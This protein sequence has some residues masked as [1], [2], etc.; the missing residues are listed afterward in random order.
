MIKSKKSPKEILCGE[1]LS[2]ARAEGEEICRLASVEADNILKR[3][4]ED[5]QK[6]RRVLLETAGAEAALRRELMVAAVPVEAARLRSARIEALLQTIRAEAGRRLLAPPAEGPWRKEILVELA[7]EAVSRLAGGAVV[8]KL[9]PADFREAG[10]GMGAAVA[11][12]AARSESEVS[13]DE[14]LSVTEG[15]VIVQDAQGRQ[16]WD[17]RLASRLERMWPELRRLIAVRTGLA[18]SGPAGGGK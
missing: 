10:A 3:A 9:S 4:G 1:I 6:A 8:L 2:Q 11:L 5:A 17:N 15:G 13:V 7:V 18:D 14:D 16:V 12:R